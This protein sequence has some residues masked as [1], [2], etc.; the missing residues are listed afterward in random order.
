VTRGIDVK[1]R[2]RGIG[3]LYLRMLVSLS[4]A[5]RCGQLERDGVQVFD[6]EDRAS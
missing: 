3:L 4:A 5:L 1:R 6:G 2:K